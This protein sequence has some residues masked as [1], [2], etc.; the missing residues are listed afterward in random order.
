MSELTGGRVNVFSGP[1]LEGDRALGLVGECDFILADAPPVPVLN[2]PLLVVFEAKQGDIEAGLGQC[3]AQMV[4]A[5]DFN[6]AAGSPPRPVYGCGTNADTWQFLKLGAG[7]DLLYDK[8]LRLLGDLPGLF[9]ALLA[10]VTDAMGGAA[11]PAAPPVPG[12]G[13]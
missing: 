3:M 7:S 9:G 2:A 8:H 11:G 10:A 1:R 4:A 12:G 13:G 5:R 6:A